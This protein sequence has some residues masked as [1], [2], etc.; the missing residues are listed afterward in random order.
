MEE[1]KQRHAAVSKVLT[2]AKSRQFSLSPSM[3]RELCYLQLRMICELIALGCLLVHG[4]IPATRTKRMQK[5]YAADWIIKRL[6]ELHPSFYPIPSVQILDPAGNVVSVE[7]IS[8]PYLT[9]VDLISL[10]AECGGVLHRGT[11]KD[12][13]PASYKPLDF[14]RIGKWAA[15]ITQLLNHHQIP[16]SDGQRQVW[17][18]MHGKDDGQVRYAVMERVPEAPTM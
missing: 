13:P 5:A 6:S 4:D 10:Y 11:L 3:S 7:P 16:M 2:D 14:V 1:L 9:K 8:K 12:I 15:K 18:I 17:V